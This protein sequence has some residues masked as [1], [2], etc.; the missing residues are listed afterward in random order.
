MVS[1][2]THP[3]AWLADSGSI[4]LPWASLWR[5]E[6]WGCSRSPFWGS[7][8]MEQGNNLHWGAHPLVCKL[9]LGAHSQMFSSILDPQCRVCR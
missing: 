8:R 7:Q 6:R 1:W 9:C 5:A 4:T 2:G 3:P